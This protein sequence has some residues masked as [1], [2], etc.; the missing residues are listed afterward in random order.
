MNTELLFLIGSLVVLGGLI[1]G[2]AGFGF[3]IAATALLTNILPP[4]QAITLM[5]LPLLAV[6]IPLIFES[7][8]N[9]LVNCIEKF[10]IFIL[11]G[12]AGTFAGLILIGAVP[13][14]IL[15][16]IVGLIA[17]VYVYFKQNIFNKP[18]N[19]KLI[20]TCFTEKWYNQSIIGILAGLIFG[21]AN[22]GLLFVTYISRIEINQRT[23]AGLLS[24]VILVTASIRAL[25]SYQTGLYTMDLLYLSIILTIPAI[26]ASSIGSKLSHKI[27]D[28]KMHTIVL[29]LIF[30]AGARIVWVNL[31]L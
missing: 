2:L 12:I 15:S 4:Q 7:S 28:K 18:F 31:G 30:V 11:S 20:T 21:I 29:L 22:V 24:L 9:K 1:K 8:Q 6:N 17:I 13:S 23:F 10:K 14:N 25:F 27:S 5:I 19:K 26:I 16:I 3:G